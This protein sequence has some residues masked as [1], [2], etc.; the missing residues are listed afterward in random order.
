M[1][2]RMILN[3]EVASVINSSNWNDPECKGFDKSCGQREIGHTQMS[4][5]TECYFVGFSFG[6]WG[7]WER[8]FKL[9]KVTDWYSYFSITCIATFDFG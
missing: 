1:P 2:E 5:R 3:I 6:G 9:G 4:L 8:H 7:R